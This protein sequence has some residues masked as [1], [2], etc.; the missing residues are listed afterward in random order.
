MKPYSRATGDSVL[1]IDGDTFILDKE[2]DIALVVVD[3]GALEL[4][5]YSG[6][7]LGVGESMKG[8][9]GGADAWI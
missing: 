3:D 7:I 1:H 2:I 5:G 4:D 6:A 8:T 9:Q